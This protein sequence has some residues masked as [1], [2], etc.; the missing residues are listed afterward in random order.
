VF[1]TPTAP[2]VV[3]QRGCLYEPR[4]AGAQRGQDIVFV[5]DDATLH[6]VHTKPSKSRAVNFGM[7]SLGERHAIRIDATEV[8]VPV[9]CDVHPWM[10]AYIGILDHPYFA[11]S[12]A[13]GSVRLSGVPAGRYTLAVWHERFGTRETDVTV[14]AGETSG[15]RIEFSDEARGR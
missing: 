13:D 11:V 3:D 15:V 14:A 9:V 12:A 2:I 5:N 8:M 1:A 7:A 4:V 10:R 6:N